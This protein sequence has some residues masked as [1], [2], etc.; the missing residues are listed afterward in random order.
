MNL[1]ILSMAAVILAAMLASRAQGI[2]LTAK[3]ERAG[4]AA[5]GELHQEHGIN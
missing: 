2:H 4:E 3:V 5:G 1:Q